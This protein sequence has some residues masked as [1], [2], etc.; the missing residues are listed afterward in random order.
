MSNIS[1]PDVKQ[2]IHFSPIKDCHRSFFH[3]KKYFAC[4]KIWKDECGLGRPM[5]LD[6]SELLS[7]ILQD[8]DE[9]REAQSEN[10]IWKEMAEGFRD[11]K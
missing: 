10:T 2:I 9:E 11:V 7:A 3:L 6:I 4:F 8:F 5:R 1:E